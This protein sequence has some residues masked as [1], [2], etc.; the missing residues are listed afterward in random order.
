MSTPTINGHDRSKAGSV[1]QGSPARAHAREG[2]QPPKRAQAP[3]PVRN[4]TR[5]RAIPR[6]IIG[7]QAHA[8]GN[9]LRPH[10]V[11]AGEKISNGWAM[12]DELPPPAQAAR[13][14][15]PPRS[16][17]YWWPVDLPANA[18]YLALLLLAYLVVQAI[19]TQRRRRVGLV[20]T[21]VAISIPILVRLLAG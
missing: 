3:E 20:L 19:A 2:D 10:L 15:F 13:Q 7:A 11:E 1:T 16:R 4:P 5:A 9:F 18:L 8:V 21:V 12:S 17:W 6:E 14:M